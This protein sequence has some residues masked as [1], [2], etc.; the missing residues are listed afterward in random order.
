MFLSAC[1]SISGVPS[2]RQDRS[3]EIEAIRPDVL[4]QY[5]AFYVAPIDIYTG[6]GDVLDRVSD[7]EARDLAESF[8]AKIIRQLGSSHAIMS[9]P[10][11]NVAII[12]IAITDV[13]TNYALMQLRPGILIPNSARGGA[14]IDARFVDSV[15]GQSLVTFRDSKQGERKGFLSGLGKWDGVERAFDQWASNLAGAIRK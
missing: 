3:P 9:S 15:T 6:T 7:R 14:S 13:S 11:K 12:K 4:K 1:S 10:A 2:S 5:H 8:R